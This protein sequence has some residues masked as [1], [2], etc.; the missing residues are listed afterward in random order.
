M[1]VNGPANRDPVEFMREA[2]KIDGVIEIIRRYPT[3]IPAVK[4]IFR[5]R[6]IDVGQAA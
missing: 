1:Y 4:E 2:I 3:C 5:Y 6:G